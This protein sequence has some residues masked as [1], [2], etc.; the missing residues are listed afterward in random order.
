MTVTLDLETI[1]LVFGAGGV[2]GV[3]I[4]WFAKMVINRRQMLA[5]VEIAK[6]E[7]ERDVEI[8]AAKAEPEAQAALDQA[9]A[10]LIRH[11]TEALQQ[12]TAEV[13]ELRLEIAEQRDEIA[14]LRVTVD[15]NNDEIARL[16]REIA[17]LNDHVTALSNELKR[18]GI[19]PPAR[20]VIT[21][22]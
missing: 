22:D 13:R 12:Q 8:G 9:V 4:G 21:A 6:I 14:R 19:D 20:S 11:Y 10:G 18:H 1:G 3:A 5:K 7:A 17:G 15:D 16:N 2:G